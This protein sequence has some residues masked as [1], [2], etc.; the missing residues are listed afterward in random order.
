MNIEVENEITKILAKISDLISTNICK[1]NENYKIEI[2]RDAETLKFFNNKP[3]EY[4]ELSLEKHINAYKSENLEIKIFKNFNKSKAEFLIR[5]NFIS[6][7]YSK[8]FDIST[9]EYIS[10]SF[11][12]TINTFYKYMEAYYVNEQEKKND[13][14]IFDQSKMISSFLGI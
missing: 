1:N 6:S 13:K 7:Y 14:L 11:F 8:S 2:F 5:F 10:D 12:S 4:F 9:R 3:L